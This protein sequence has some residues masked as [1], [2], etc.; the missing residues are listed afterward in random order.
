MEGKTALFKTIYAHLNIDGY[1]LNIDVILAPSDGLEQW[2][3]LLWKQWIAERKSFLGIQGNQYDDI[4]RRYKD[5]TDNKPDTLDAQLKAL[6]TIGFKDVDC[7][8]KYGVF[9]IYGGRK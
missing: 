2:Y 8:Y 4:I 3:L 9:A 1:F 7:F 6:Q 5:N